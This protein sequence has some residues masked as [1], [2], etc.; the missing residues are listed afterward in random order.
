MKLNPILARRMRAQGILL[1]IPEDDSEIGRSSAIGFYIIQ[2]GKC[3]ILPLDEF[4]SG[5]SFDLHI[6]SNVSWPFEISKVEAEFPWGNVPINWLPE[7]DGRDIGPVGY[8]FPSELPL[9]YERT[10]VIN[11]YVGSHRKLRRGSTA[12]GLLLGI[13]ERAPEDAGSPVSAFVYVYD[14]FDR[15]YEANLLVFIQRWDGGI[16]PNPKKE[17]RKSLLECPDRVNPITKS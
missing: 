6:A 9:E 7:P 8:R 2:N 1:D 15:K 14:Q 10:I 3:E 11:H 17:Q 5:D 4:Q 12:S 13:G 16:R